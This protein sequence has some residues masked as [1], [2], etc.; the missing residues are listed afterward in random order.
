M[1]AAAK[2]LLRG[3]LR[4]KLTDGSTID[5]RRS[6]ILIDRVDEYVHI[7]IG[8]CDAILVIEKEAV[9]H[10]LVAS[11]FHESPDFNCIMITGKGCKRIRRYE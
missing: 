7:E 4:I 11:S 3:D 10:S 6:D 2:G 5:S 8:L 9:Y 1:A